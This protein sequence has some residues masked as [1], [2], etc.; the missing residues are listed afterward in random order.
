MRIWC[1]RPVRGITRS[2]VKRPSGRLK[3]R[4]TLNAVSAGA[5]SGPTQTFTPTPPADGPPPGGF[6]TP[7]LAPPLPVP[8]REVLLVRLAVFPKTAHLA[9]RGVLPGDTHEPAGLAIEPV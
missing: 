8:D 4:T 3:R 9:R 5:P 6:V 2:S 7:P 1:L